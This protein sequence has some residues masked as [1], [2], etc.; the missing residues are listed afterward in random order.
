MKKF[1]VT[2]REWVIILLLIGVFLGI[3]IPAW[4]RYQQ[5]NTGNNEPGSANSGVVDTGTA[6][7]P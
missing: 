7:A 1:L 3:A 5:E 2:L 4:L 6:G